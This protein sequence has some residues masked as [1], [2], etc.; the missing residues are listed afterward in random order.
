MAD[1]AASLHC[2]G[3]ILDPIEDGAEVIFNFAKHEA[4]EQR[5]VAAC[6]RARQNASARKKAKIGHCVV[7]RRRPLFARRFAPFFDGCGCPGNAP[8]CVIQRLIG[9]SAPGTS[10]PVLAGPDLLRDQRLK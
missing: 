7:E 4:V 9:S 2:Q 3:R 8:K 10:K 6:A 1:A 5:H